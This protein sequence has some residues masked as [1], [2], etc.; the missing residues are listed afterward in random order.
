MTIKDC[1][2]GVCLVAPMPLLAQNADLEKVLS[3]MDAASARFHSAAAAFSADQYTA[4]VQQHDLQQG[5]TAFRRGG[6]S[7]EMAVHV[8]SEGGQPAERDLLYKGGELDF[9]EPNLQQETIYRS[10]QSYESF[11]TI[12]FGGSGKDLQA[13]WNITFE[14]METI[15]GTRVAKLDLVSKQQQVRSNF[16]HITVWIDPTRSLAYK[17]EFF[18]PSGDTRTVTYTDIRYNTSLPAS[19]FT[20]KVA[21]GTQRVVK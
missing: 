2:L 5:T 21:P 1:L 3:Q 7:T 13:G 18:E 15:G 11:F 9:Y 6:S 4:V 12:G 17:Q 14:G 19:T 8:T 16:S 10:R 20:L